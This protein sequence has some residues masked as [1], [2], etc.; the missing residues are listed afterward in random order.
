[1]KALLDYVEWAHNIAVE[2]ETKKFDSYKAFKIWKEDVEKQTTGSNFNKMGRKIMYFKCHRNGFYKARSDK[3]SSIKMAGSNKI[4]GNCPSKM[5]VCEDIENQV[6]LELTKTHL[7]TWNRFGKNA[8]NKRRKRRNSKK[9][10][11]ENSN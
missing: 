8:N 11:E 2:K 1:M 6:Y 9:I 5:K 7:E 4:T 3:K 10:R